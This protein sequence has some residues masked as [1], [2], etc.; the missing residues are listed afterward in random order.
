M[1]LIVPVFE[2]GSTN[3]VPAA[4][5]KPVTK[6]LHI[7]GLTP[8]ITADDLAKCLKN[9]GVVKSMDGFGMIDAVG[10]PRKFGYITLETTTK[11][12]GR[13]ESHGPLCSAP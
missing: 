1:L 5:D 3:R 8:A 7:S 9:F 12:L 4:M 13:C 11:N 10:Q 6:R 2:G